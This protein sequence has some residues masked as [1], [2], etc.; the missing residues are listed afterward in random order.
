MPGKPSE[1]E[2]EYFARMEYEKRQKA[3]REKGTGMESKDR[4]KLKELHYMHC[5]KCGMDLIEIDYRG[6]RV[7][8]C[9]GCEG[10]WLDAGEL[11]AISEL[12]KG[13]LDKWFGV[14]KK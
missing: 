14:F 4:A 2:E 9:S 10:V 1:K 8:K 7:D 12:E 3:L 5:P 6:I 11:E 13:G